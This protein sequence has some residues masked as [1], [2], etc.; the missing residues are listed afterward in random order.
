MTSEISFD[1][2]QMSF[3]N[4]SLPS[5]SW[6]SGSVSKSKSMVPASA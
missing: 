6:P 5:S 4:T 3:R 1:D 2:G